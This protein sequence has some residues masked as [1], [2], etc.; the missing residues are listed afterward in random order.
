MC[1][2]AGIYR[3]DGG[4]V[5]EPRVRAMTDALAHRGPND[6]GVFTHGSVGLG[7]RRLSIIDLS[8][9][10]HQ[11]MR[12]ADGRWALVYNGEVYNYLE[13]R[14]ELAHHHAFTTDTDTEVLLAA[15]RHWGPACL[16]RLNGMFAFAVYDRETGT[17]FA[18]RDRFGIKPFYYY[19]DD[20]QLIFASEIQA[21]LTALGRRLDAD[22]GLILDYLAFNRTD[23]TERTFFRG[24]RKLQHGHHLAATRAGTTIK[25]W[26][27]LAE[28]IGDPFESAEDYREVFASSVR[29]RLRSDV[30]VGVCLSGGL[31]SS[32]VVSTVVAL[33]RPDVNT[34][35]AV[36][37]GFSKDESG[38]IREYESQLENM[39]FTRPTAQ[40]FFDG[41]DGFVRAQNEP[42]PSSSPYAQYEVMKLAAERVSVTIDGQGADEQLAGYHYFFGFLFKELLRAGRLDRLSR[43]IAGYARTHRSAYALKSLAYL[44]LPGSARHR[45]RVEHAGY[46]APAFFEA[47]RGENVIA[48]RLYGARSLREALLFHFEYKLEH[49]LKWGDHNSMAFSVES[50]VPFLDYRL[51]ERTLATSSE[52]ILSDGTTKRILREAMAGRVPERLRLRQDKVGFATPEDDWF[53][54]PP[55]ESFIR[56][57]LGSASFAE[58]GYVDAA[59]ALALYERHLA[60]AL[61]ISKDIWKWLNL[62][63]WFQTFVDGAPPAEAAPARPLPAL[64]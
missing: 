33:G 7:H 10:G 30:P 18:A 57:T 39:F 36:F 26:Y 54:Q 53:R 40:T 55:F 44:M 38:F 28:R 27:D 34:F 16:D 63:L 56:D 20:D 12:S 17:L 25:R 19:E 52:M 13:L 14:R 47:H 59:R 3:F 21:I 32:S 37:E 9:A 4:P 22:D 23:H 62:E 45:L 31:D 61:N 29:L 8:A 43:E 49:L 41:M 58:R 48:D 11:P 42:T 2:I 1:G 51:V 64:A 60:G 15:Y 50:R 35:S 46:I 5:A 6:E 24:V